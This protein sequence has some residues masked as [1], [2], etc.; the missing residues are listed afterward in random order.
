MLPDAILVQSYNHVSDNLNRPH[1]RQPDIPDNIALVSR[2]ISNRAGV[3]VLLA[4]ALAKV[5]D[6]SVDIRK[7]YTEIDATDTF[8]GRAFDEKYIAPFVAQHRLPCNPTTAFLT[9]ALRNRN[10]VLTPDLNLSGRP[11]EVYSALLQ[12]LTDVHEQKISAQQLLDETIRQLIL[13]RDEN[14]QRLNSLI[15]GLKSA[16]GGTPL[17]VEQIISLIRQHLATKGASRLPVLIVAA[18][19]KAAQPYLR[20]KALPLEAHNAADRQ[21]QAIGDVQITLITDDN[22]VTCY[23]MKMRRVTSGDIDLALQEKI[24]RTAH[25]IDN[26]IFITTDKID[27]D[28]H[29]YAKSIYDL[30]GV[31]MAILDCMDFLRHFLHLFHRH[32]TIFLDAYQDF[33]LAE[34]ESAVSHP[35]KEVFLTLRQAAESD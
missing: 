25:Q 31:E 7:P 26:Y 6:N 35:L 14:K 2:S 24:L 20:E 3:R 13:F 30:T 18:A 15:A 32:R 34:P 10:T 5:H 28:V 27:P 33:V 9:P 23:E 8:S 11:R 1:V 21:T 16:Q 17:S 12:L 4:C 22:I 29:E 19:Y